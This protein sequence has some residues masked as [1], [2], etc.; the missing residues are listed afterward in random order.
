EGI[1]LNEWHAVMV[2]RHE[3]LERRQQ[4]IAKHSLITA[5]QQIELRTIVGTEWNPWTGSR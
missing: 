5:R 4:D 2:F 3:N 1:C